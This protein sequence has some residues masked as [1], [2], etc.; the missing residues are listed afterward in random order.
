MELSAQYCMPDVSR[1]AILSAMDI[2]LQV[3]E[4]F[5]CICMRSIC[6]FCLQPEI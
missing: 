4:A 5:G 6:P 3:S 1:P 2:E